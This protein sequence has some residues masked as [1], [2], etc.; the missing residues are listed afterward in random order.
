MTFP[1]EAYDSSMEISITNAHLA[2]NSSPAPAR[3]LPLSARPRIERPQQLAERLCGERHRREHVP[4]VVRPGEAVPAV[5]LGRG[6]QIREQHRHQTTLSYRRLSRLRDERG[7][8][9]RSALERRPAL[10][11]EKLARL[12]C[13]SARRASQRK[14]RAAPSAKIPT[15]AILGGAVRADRHVKTAYPATNAH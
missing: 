15:V 14:Y 1:Q 10:A 12:V 11:A 2:E 3:R 13:R 5:L 6:G 9:R 7:K 8:R 4:E